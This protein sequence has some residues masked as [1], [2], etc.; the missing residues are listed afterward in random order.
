[1]RTPEVAHTEQ[2]MLGAATM[3]SCTKLQLLGFVVHQSSM[4]LKYESD[5]LVEFLS[6]YLVM[7]EA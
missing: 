1:M 6:M 2:V 7:H 4:T 3:T 5:I